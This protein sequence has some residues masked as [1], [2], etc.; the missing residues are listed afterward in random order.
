MKDTARTLS[1]YVDG[2]MIRTKGHDIIEELAEYA[3]V[4][5]I[6]GLTDDFHP[7]QVMADVQTIYE[8]TALTT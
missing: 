2:I 4:P 3:S 8:H 1:R 6:N 5:V 7:C